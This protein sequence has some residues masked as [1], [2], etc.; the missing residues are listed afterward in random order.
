[1][2]RWRSSHRRRSRQECHHSGSCSTPCARLVS[3]RARAHASDSARNEAGRASL[4]RGAETA[5]GRS[6]TSD[7]PRPKARAAIAEIIA[8]GRRRLGSAERARS[9]RGRSRPALDRRRRLDG[10]RGDHDDYALRKPLSRHL[11]HGL[12]DWAA[13]FARALRTRQ[14]LHPAPIPHEAAGNSRRTPRVAARTGLK[15]LL[16]HGI[17]AY[18]RSARKCHDRPVTP[19]VAGSSPAAP[20]KVLQSGIFSCR[21]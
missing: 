10:R 7:D 21:V 8:P 19:E 6:G 5:P 2:A 12:S 1:M 11:F 3:T 20:V 17:P 14:R 16:L 13:V 9:T 4:P 18:P 15:A